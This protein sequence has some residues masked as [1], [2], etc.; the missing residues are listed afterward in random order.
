MKR[1]LPVILLT[2]VLVALIA[3]LAVGSFAFYTHEDTAV[4]VITTRGL[5]IE[6]L[7]KTADG[8]DFPAEGVHVMPGDT[9]SKI[10]SVKNTADSSCYVRIALEKG[11]NDELLD[12][13]GC[14]KI[15]INTVDW[16]YQDGYY[17]Y[18]SV[19]APGATTN[20]LFTEVLIDGRSVNN[21]YMNK[22]FTLDVTAYAVQSANNGTSALDATGWPE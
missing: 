18:N 10:V 6:L 7:E 5:K 1:K 16:T 22:E 14:L 2:A 4:N 19:L 12:A 15:D 17:Y 8:S 11:I 13:E 3:V 20:P 21:D 9:V